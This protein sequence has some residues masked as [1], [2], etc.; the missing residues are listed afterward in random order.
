MYLD[1]NLEMKDNCKFNHLILDSNKDTSSLLDESY[2]SFC[3]CMNSDLK[4]MGKKILFK[5]EKDLQVM[6]ELGFQHI[7][8]MTKK[9]G[10]R[11]YE[12]NR[13]IYVPLIRQIISDCS[14]SKKCPHIAI[15][16]DNKDICIWCRNNKFLIVLTPRNKGYLLNTA[17][18]V[19]YS[20]KINQIEKKIN[21]NGL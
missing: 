16:K 11:L 6:K 19:I 21:E 12:P 7:V 20:H 3:E 13:M 18:P 4:F 14:S 9:F 8:S 10:M 15:Y 1:G 17:Y 5:T 2:V